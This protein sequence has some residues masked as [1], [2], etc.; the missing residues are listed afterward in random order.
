M[1]QEVGI[2]N[3]PIYGVETAGQYG[4]NNGQVLMLGGDTVH[5]INDGSPDIPAVLAFDNLAQPLM[6]NNIGSKIAFGVPYGASYDIKTQKYPT[7]Y[8][9]EDY[10]R[11]FSRTVPQ[12]PNPID[13][14][15]LNPYPP[16]PAP[17]IP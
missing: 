9:Y 3:E 4:P 10:V 16:G 1:K 11:I 8:V 2:T 14:F 6:W 15:N 7:Y 5:V 12:A 17:Y 13:N